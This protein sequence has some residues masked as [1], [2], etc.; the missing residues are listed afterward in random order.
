MEWNLEDFDN[1]L[2]TDETI[3][4]E[5]HRNFAPD[6]SMTSEEM[7]NLEA[8][9]A[10]QS[11][12]L[13]NKWQGE[14]G[15]GVSIRV[16]SERLNL[17]PDPRFDQP[18]QGFDGVF[19]DQDGKLVVVESKFTKNGIHSLH[20]DQMQP[21]WIDRTAEKMANPQSAM[22]TPGNAEI[23][24]EIKEIGVE[25]VRRFV[26]ATDPSTLEAKIYEGKSEGSWQIV[27]QWTVLDI[28]Q[29]YLE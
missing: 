3:D 18:N 5:L 19:K 27:D 28:E 14:I 29:P 11:E 26:V 21:E 7:K 16:A 22:Y 20:K 24:S 13:K 4:K 2:R 15:E 8:S 10:S 9:N 23:A 12:A 6:E 17:T 25:N 1:H